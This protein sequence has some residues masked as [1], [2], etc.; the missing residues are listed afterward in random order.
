MKKYITSKY[1]AF[2]ISNVL[3]N[4]KNK[5]YTVFNTNADERLEPIAS[6]SL[7]NHQIDGN[8][9]TFR[10]KLENEDGTEKS[11]KV[12]S[13]REKKEIIVPASQFIFNLNRDGYVEVKRDKKRTKLYLDFNQG[14]FKELTPKE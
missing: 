5:D 9:M 12:W 4:A 7:P 8:A 11:Y 13:L 2:K 14:N 10:I 6:F 1:F 3:F